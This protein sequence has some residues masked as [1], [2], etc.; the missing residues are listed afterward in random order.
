[1]EVV[2]SMPLWLATDW[3]G[4]PGYC[5]QAGAAQQRRV[6]GSSVGKKRDCSAVTQQTGGVAVVG[7]ASALVDV[8]VVGLE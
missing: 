5:D 6:C 7:A 2:V 1:M 4:A 3:R 8:Q